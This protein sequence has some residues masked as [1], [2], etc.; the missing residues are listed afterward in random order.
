M[1][2]L[3]SEGLVLPVAI[4]ML[5]AF[6]VPRLFARVLPEG[7]TPLLLNAFLST[8]VL[9]KLSAVLFVGLYVWQGLPL[10]DVAAQG[11]A[12]S[13]VFFGRLGI[14]AAIIWAPV[15]LLSVAGLP[16]KWVHETW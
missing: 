3:L 4:L 13:I 1:G 12:S 10:T 7:V 11:L 9:F 8:V 6:A 14:A 15:M 16:R 5:A 2:A